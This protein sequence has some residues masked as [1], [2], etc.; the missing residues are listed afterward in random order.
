MK[1][2]PKRLAAVVGAGT[3]RFKTRRDDVDLSE[4]LIEGAEAALEDAGLEM[5]DIDAVVLAQ[6]P[7]PLHGVG[8]PEQTAAAALALGGRPL[9]RVHTGGATGISA[10]QVGWWSVVSGR[11]ETVLVVGAERM[12]D[13]VLGAQRV[14]NEI[15]D[16]AYEALM[17][18]NTIANCSLMTVR[19]MDR[20]G[21]TEKEFAEIAARLRAN[22]ARNE[23][24]H[25][26]KTITVEEILQSPI[27][28]W[29]VRIG[30]SCPRSTGAAAT[31]ITSADMADRLS[32]PPA[33]IL[34]MTA[35]TDTYFM[36]DRM[37]VD[38]E[39]EFIA[40]HNLAQA[41]QEAYEMA[42]IKDPAAELDV[43]EPYV[44]FSP[45]E[46]MM[47]EAMQLAPAGGAIALGQE[48]A[49]AFGGKVVVSPSG[50]VMCS[51]PISVTALVRVAEVAQQ[52]RGRAGGQQVGG[53]RTGLATG[54]GGD[55]QFY[56][57]AVVSGDDP[58]I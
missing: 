55:S 2:R 40:M 44:P 22:G 13:N 6:G 50:G 52:V 34:A 1:A 48:G 41:T 28:T 25:L 31:V 37:S 51:N 4:L 42:G 36:G 56:G 12:G 3:S 23:F 18:L 11:F 58:R 20:Y 5:S 16:P 19:Y 29:P 21:A 47:L 54:A 45:Y 53:A 35:R 17:P 49:W 43:V 26:R 7:D 32:V 39:D 38:G 9:M 15:W 24:A 10:A 57:V 8:H 30:T 14:L 33:W 46:P 27:L